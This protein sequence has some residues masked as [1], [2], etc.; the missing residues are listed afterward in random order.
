MSRGFMYSLAL[1]DDFSRTLDRWS[2][3]LQGAVNAQ[4][5]ASQRLTLTASKMAAGI[6][7]AIAATVPAAAASFLPLEN[8]LARLG[9]VFIGTNNE[10]DDGLNRSLASA[11]RWSAVHI[12]STTE[13]IEAQF[14][15][16]TAGLNVEESMAG[17]AASATLATATGEKM[18]QSAQLMASLFNTFGQTGDLAKM[19]MQDA[20]GDIGDS[21]AKTMQAFQVT[22]Q[23]LRQGL[24][25]VTGQAV[26]LGLSLDE[27]NVALGIL[28]TAGIRASNA[29]TGLQNVFIRMDEAI[30]KLHLDITAFTDDMGNFT[31]ISD[32]IDELSKKTEGLTQ[33][34][35]VMAI[36]E[37]MGQ[38]AARTTL[39]LM[40]QRQE[41]RAMTEQ[42]G[43]TSGAAERMAARIEATTTSR[44][45]IAANNI[46]NV[47][48]RMGESL[49]PAL[50]AAANAL[51]TIMGPWEA[52]I[53]RSPLAAAAIIGIAGAA[54]MA[55]AAFQGMNAILSITGQKLITVKVA[56]MS[57][58]KALAFATVIGAAAAAI[59]LFV[60][61][62][63]RSND[64]VGE[65]QS[66]LGNPNFGRAETVFQ[67]LANRAAAAAEAVDELG[68]NVIRAQG[69]LEK[70]GITVEQIQ[71]LGKTG[72]VGAMMEPALIKS[73]TDQF[74]VFGYSQVEAAANAQM[75]SEAIADLQ[76]KGISL[77]SSLHGMGQ[78]LKTVSGA[79]IQ[80][81]AT[82]SGQFM[83]TMGKFRDAEATLLEAAAKDARFAGAKTAVEFF[84]ALRQEVA[85]LGNIDS[86][87]LNMEVGGAVEP[88]DLEDFAEQFSDQLGAAVGKFMKNTKATS[89]LMAGFA[90]SLRATDPVLADALQ[91]VLMPFEATFAEN[92][93]RVGKTWIGSFT[94]SLS[95]GARGVLTQTLT[96]AEFNLQGLEEASSVIES[97]M[98]AAGAAVLVAQGRL[99]AFNHEQK[100]AATA[101]I[102]AAESLAK[103]EKAQSGGFRG[104][105]LKNN[106][107]LL[108]RIIASEQKQLSIA[109]QRKEVLEGIASNPFVKIFAG[110]M[111]GE[112]LARV[113]ADIAVHKQMLEDLGA[114]YDETSGRIAA[115]GDRL[116][117]E[118]MLDAAPLADALG[119]TIEGGTSNQIRQALFTSVADSIKDGFISGILEGVVI[120]EAFTALFDATGLKD[121]IKAAVSA[122]AATGGLEGAG[123]ALTSEVAKINSEMT[124]LGPNFDGFLTTAQT[125]LQSMFNNLASVMGVPEM[126]VK[127]AN[128][129]LEDMNPKVSQ[130]VDTIAEL[131]ASLL[132]AS[133]TESAFGEQV[134]SL[135]RGGGAFGFTGE[136]AEGRLSAASRGL[137]IARQE[138]LE[139]TESARALKEIATESLRILE[140]RRQTAAVDTDSGFN[141]ETMQRFAQETEQVTQSLNAV[142]PDRYAT[143]ADELERGR[144]A[145]EAIREALALFSSGTL[146]PNQIS[147][148]G[149]GGGGGVTVTR[150]DVVVNVTGTGGVS[151]QTIDEMER[152][153][154]AELE[155]QIGQLRTA[156]EAAR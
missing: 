54:T 100:K 60:N 80:A 110:E 6:G 17:V 87:Q 97:R 154:R 115:F 123:A 119:K 46:K 151:R 28:N 118:E 5:T 59:G 20:M 82:L 72:D 88:Q 139:N 130:M 90:D 131:Q 141:S 7:L 132:G 127:R 50:A 51:V 111:V 49:V 137:E 86:A 40:T 143:L 102:A 93:D 65:L 22:I 36:Q 70:F 19:E 47:F 69:K 142:Q 10:I 96:G 125:G 126:A 84:A 91:K 3:G 152:A 83:D 147:V 101:G 120:G 149:S 8:A 92:G 11:R 150:G 68:A 121:R 95:R 21:I 66:E 106:I 153:L 79:S 31:S 145:A 32:F 30:E 61:E 99:E 112:R 16:A 37:A 134:L 27:V 43:E 105:D 53:T 52:L 140:L 128:Q 64:I 113:N 85:R 146:V 78:A 12:Q 107:A 56:A 44:M 67:T 15:L 9:T 2:A 81:D 89:D 41:L 42:F 77:E 57:F 116:I 33:F 71:D 23:P 76:T 117:T 35:K 34:E 108:D 4:Q 122:G 1:R 55:A 94:E 24:A 109:E 29:G 13:V 144:D 48:Q 129:A 104:T 39:V 136:D 73:A 38:R 148:N 62:L 124:A 156:V 98:Q 138:R 135:V 103:L 58:L 26:Q 18:A 14:E 133:T 63:V 155:V 45:K 25:F 114:K 75:L 74:K